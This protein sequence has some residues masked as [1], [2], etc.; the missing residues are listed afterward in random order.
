MIWEFVRAL[1][2]HCSR[3]ARAVLFTYLLFLHWIVCVRG[4][5]GW[6]VVLQWW[7][8]L[9]WRSAAADVCVITHRSTCSMHT[10]NTGGPT[11][12]PA[13]LPTFRFTIFFA[14]CA[15]AAPRVRGGSWMSCPSG[16]GC[17]LSDRSH[18]VGALQS[19]HSAYTH[20]RGPTKSFPRVGSRNGSRALGGF[21][22]N[23]YPPC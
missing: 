6:C 22:L 20:T 10:P 9:H 12:S 1:L 4:R 19:T 2:V 3:C 16:R 8:V 13:L 11:R 21:V 18:Y 14:N 7:I 23:L 5:A 17:T 15:C